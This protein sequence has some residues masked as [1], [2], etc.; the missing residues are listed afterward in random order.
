MPAH[1]LVLDFGGLGDEVHLLPALWL[2]RQRWPRA[3]LHV[4]V[5]AHVASLFKLTPWVDRV[6]TYAKPRERKLAALRGWMRV[7]RAQRYGVVIDLKSTDRSSWLAWSTR[8]PLRIGRQP[9]DGGPFGWR[10]LFHQVLEQPYYAEPMYLQ[11][12]RCLRALGFGAEQDQP[13][14][15]VEIDPQLRRA[16]GIAAE[17]EGRYIHLSPCTTADARELASAQLVDLIAALRERFPAL[18]LVLSCAGTAREQSKLAQILEL[19]P[20]PPWKV[21]PGT[22]D[23]AALA[24]VIQTAAFNLSGDTGSLHLA[25]M[26][27]VPAVAWFRAHRGQKEWIPEGARYRVLVAEGGAA[28]ALHGIQTAQLLDAASRVLNQ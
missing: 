9:A 6:W 26:T 15:H 7:L 3:Q 12:W 5:N 4:L 14:F 16:A 10:W 24:A 20:E 21:F 13:A 19:L 25:M 27:R 18:R 8:A 2:V 23:V 17:D 22:L 1:V 28:D 11:K